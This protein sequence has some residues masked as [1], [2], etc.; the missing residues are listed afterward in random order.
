MRG[1]RDL[2]ASEFLLLGHILRSK[3]LLFSFVHK[4]WFDLVQRARGQP[5]H[6]YYSSPFKSQL[7]HLE[8]CVNAG[9]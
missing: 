6:N 9:M 4:D 5:G 1:H 2:H 8:T 3:G 7:P